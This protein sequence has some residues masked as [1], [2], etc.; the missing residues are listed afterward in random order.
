M[1]VCEC[2]CVCEREREKESRL[3]DLERM[4]LFSTLAFLAK[5]WNVARCVCERERV[6]VCVVCVCERE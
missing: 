1:S 2:V 6:R 4:N 5:L 3:I